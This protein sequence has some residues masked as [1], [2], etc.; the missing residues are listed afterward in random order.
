MENRGCVQI[1]AYY[2]VD[3]LSQGKKETLDR[4]RKESAT[5]NIVGYLT[6]RYPHCIFNQLGHDI[7]YGLNDEVKNLALEAENYD[8]NDENNG[9]AVLLC[10]V[11]DDL[12]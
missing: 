12:L 2:L 3:L 7:I 11:I 6:S 1:F 9:L 5:G 8:L 10:N 4:I